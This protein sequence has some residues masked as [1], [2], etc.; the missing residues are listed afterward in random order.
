MKT[1]TE[2]LDEFGKL[3]V[4]DVFDDNFKYFKDIIA[5]NTKWNT[6]KGYSNVFSKL[7]EADKKI[8]QLFFLE[9]LK[10]NLFSFLSIF[11]NHEQF[12][13][14]FE[15]GEHKVNLVDISEMLKSEPIIENGWIARFSKELNKEQ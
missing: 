10:T 5:D 13:L 1:D 6:G 4:N 2:I 7:N 12:K 15:E 11:E 8:I 3:V 14:S 9:M